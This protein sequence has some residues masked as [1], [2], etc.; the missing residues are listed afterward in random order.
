MNPTKNGTDRMAG[1][2]LEDLPESSIVSSR[3]P[4]LPSELINEIDDVVLELSR[5]S[6]IMRG[7]PLLF[8]VLGLFGFLACFSLILKIAFPLDREVVAVVFVFPILAFCGFWIV[9]LLFKTDL[10]I[11]TD[12]PVRFDRA[13]RKV[14]VY[15]H[16]YG[17][18]PFRKWP[19]KVNIFDW[20]DLRASIF[21]YK[22]FSGKVYMQRFSLWLMVDGASD[23]DGRFELMGNWPTTKEMHDAWDFCVEYMDSGVKDLPIHGIRNQE[24]TFRRSLFHYV[25]IFDPSLDGKKVRA[26]MTAGDWA[27]NLP[28]LLMTF[29]IF[30]PMGVAHYFAMRFSPKVVWPEDIDA[31][32]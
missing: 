14:Y 30:L 4:N 28:F 7:G 20:D 8:A 29:W 12:R 5:S 22:G 26:R 18:N 21:I 23:V 31:N 2:W 19:V 15:E 16:R 3:T 1:R 13:L 6:I 24:I 11:S 25:R 10:A 32:Q 9:A 17:L 27:F